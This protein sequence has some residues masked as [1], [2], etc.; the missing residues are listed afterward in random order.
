M[1]FSLKY[2][3]YAIDRISVRGCKMSDRTMI[4]SLTIVILLLGTNLLVLPQGRIEILNG[5]IE[6]DR[7]TGKDQQD[8]STVRYTPK[9]LNFTVND[10]SEFEIF[11]EESDQVFIFHNDDGGLRL[12]TDE[13][14][15]D[16]FG[17]HT[18]DL[19]I[20]V[21]TFT[22]NSGSILKPQSS[23]SLEVYARN[24][25]MHDGSTIVLSGLGLEVVGKGEDGENADWSGGGGGGGGS[26]GNTG[27]DGGDGPRWGGGDGGE[28]GDQHGSGNGFQISIGSKGGNGGDADT[29]GGSGGNGGGNILIHAENIYINGTI[30]ANG[31][32][33][34]N[35]GDNGDVG[36]GG[37]GGSGGGIM[38]VGNDVLLGSGCIID[39]RGG[40]G[41]NSGNTFVNWGESG[42]GG[43]GGSGGRVKVFFE[44]SAVDDS[45]DGV[46][47]S[48]GAGGIP[49]TATQPSRVGEKG[50]DGA[51]GTYE[52]LNQE[53]DFPLEYLPTGSYLSKPFD[54]NNTSPHYDSISFETETPLGTEVL[55]YTQT[56]SSSNDDPDEPGQWGNWSEAYAGSPEQITSE[57]K[58]WIRFKVDLVN[59]GLDL[60]TTPI[61]KN[62]KIEYHLHEATFGLMAEIT[63]QTLNPAID[64]TTEYAFTFQD[65]DLH[66]LSVFQGKMVLKETFSG[67]EKV[68]LNG[69]IMNEDNA[70]F[71]IVSPGQYRLSF[72]LSPEPYIMDGIWQFY[73]EVYDGNTDKLI[74]DDTSGLYQL[75][76]TTNY[77][78]FIDPD[79]LSLSSSII[80][81]PGAHSTDI[82]FQLEDQDPYPPNNFTFTLKIKM[83]NGSAEYFLINQEKPGNVEE[84][85]I[86]NTRAGYL[87]SYEFDP[88]DLVEP[89]EY[90]MY[91]KV[92]DDHGVESIIDPDM[93]DV[94]LNLRNN[95]PPSPPTWILPDQT[96][97]QTPRIVWDTAV[98]LDEDPLTYY[99]QIGSFSTGNDILLMKSTGTNNFYDITKPLPHG[100]YYIQVWSKDMDFFSIV[101]EEVLSIMEDINSP[102]SPPTSIDPKHTKETLPNIQWSGAYDIDGDNL[103][104]F[105]Q[106][107]T[108]PGKDDVLNKRT[109]GEEA[110]YQMEKP[111]VRGNDY[112]IRLWSH[113]GVLESYPSDHMF[114]V[115]TQSNHRPYPPT[116]LEPKKT[117]DPTP[118]IFW[119]EGY[120]E[121]E[122]TLSYYIR[123]GTEEGNGNIID[124]T[125]TGE[126][127]YFQVVQ[128]LSYRTYYVSI[129]CED[130]D[131]LVSEIL[132]GIITITV[133]GNIPPTAPTQV[134]PT[135]TPERYPS[136]SWS[137]ATDENPKDVNNLFYFIQIGSEPEGN[138]Y[139]SWQV[140]M[141]NSYN[142]TSY[143]PDGIYYVQ[144]RTSDGIKNSSTYYHKLYVGKLEP[145]VEFM[146][147]Q[148]EVVKGGQYKVMLN[149]SNRGTI[150]D[151]LTLNL[152]DIDN[153]QISLKGK[154]NYTL[155]PGQG[156]SLEMTITIMET[157][158]HKAAGNQLDV[159]LTSVSG[160]TSRSILPLVKE[161]KETDSQALHQ[162]N[163]FWIILVI[164]LLLLILLIVIVRRR[165]RWE[166]GGVD[167][168][169]TVAVDGLA[170][171]GRKRRR[172]EGV[173]RIS[174]TPLM[175]PKAKRVSMAIY[176][177]E[178]A[179]LPSSSKPDLMAL[180]AS[181]QNLPEIHIPGKTVGYGMSKGARQIKALPQQS[182]VRN[183]DLR[184]PI[185]MP[186]DITK[187]DGAKSTKEFFEILEKDQEPQKKEKKM[188][189]EVKV[190]VELP[191]D[192]K[193][194]EIPMVEAVEIIDPEPV[195]APPEIP[196]DSP[197][198]GVEKKSPP[199]PP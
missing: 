155:E 35:S 175:D 112:Y 51:V 53:F 58:R 186:G 6:V 64:E 144:I 22:L 65:D 121:D 140:T 96:A 33:G 82:S 102:P 5:E 199:P 63:N 173:T 46:N 148:L 167:Y 95:N 27:G 157:F 124:W 139:L 34:G 181:T 32:K 192:N 49:G 70:D 75:D 93:S 133:E 48:G 25:I 87:I 110:R 184:S 119:T 193:E 149:I 52:S 84:L 170:S 15:L 91:I 30:E 135:F 182:S 134:E 40:N 111:L 152:K 185:S 160:D 94:I 125:P 79:S 86:E 59:T 156:L 90:G 177:A 150:Q 89:G 180:P 78:P 142:V 104:Y 45:L 164:L 80:P 176:N 143:L 68:L 168:T 163:W 131:G 71:K 56:A 7:L 197:P 101:H 76:I 154:M 98:D 66:P 55:I 151:Q 54:T 38:L 50:D 60:H 196:P 12:V 47:V 77:S 146:D 100:N 8:I 141:T 188:D 109:T 37:G 120:D 178:R 194:E 189:L 24:F 165:N 122:D 26:Y 123:I 92:A 9:I 117:G 171:R 105:I 81:I 36:G 23:D 83:V 99:I 172:P 169:D 62:I 57:N 183:I 13:A 1:V 108:G 130:P 4:L 159:T 128:N 14:D 29:D 198:P 132:T 103:T 74:I 88:N 44:D 69:S 153:V 162:N 114:R 42:G 147:E 174:D 17:I 107:G 195:P 73:F 106:I 10:Q 43:G 85:S 166:D 19:P 2:L 72:H 127:T 116:S 118:L 61:L 28:G 39:A 41:G 18:T 129:R 187:D 138:Q 97:E 31:I 3:I 137:G 190:E 11:E 191:K 158:D 20:Y 115:L 161:K 16:I 113:D 21:E 67:E 145:F 126:S 136:L 179:Q